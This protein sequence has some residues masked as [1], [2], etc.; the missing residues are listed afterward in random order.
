MSE[1]AIY[2]NGLL[3]GLLIGSGVTLIICGRIFVQVSRHWKKVSDDW[4]TIS[5]DWRQI[6]QDWQDMA[7]MARRRVG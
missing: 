4:K 5:N 3:M 7:E 1:I 2:A 6:C